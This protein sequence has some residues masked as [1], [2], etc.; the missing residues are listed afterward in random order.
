[1]TRPKYGLR[2]ALAI[3]LS[4]VLFHWPCNRLVS[5]ASAPYQAAAKPRHRTGSKTAARGQQIKEHRREIIKS[6]DTVQKVESPSPK[7]N[8]LLTPGVDDP[9]MPYNNLLATLPV[10]DTSEFE[11]P[12]RTDLPAIQICKFPLSPEQAAVM[13]NADGSMNI[14]KQ[15]PFTGVF[16][17]FDTHVNETGPLPTVYTNFK[18]I[19]T[20]F[21]EE[22]NLRGHYERWLFFDFFQLADPTAPKTAPRLAV[23]QVFQT[24]AWDPNTWERY[25]G[26][27]STPLPVGLP[28]CSKFDPDVNEA[29]AKHL[30]DMTRGL[31]WH[32]IELALQNPRWYEEVTDSVEGAILG[33]QLCALALK[34]AKRDEYQLWLHVGLARHES[35]SRQVRAGTARYFSILKRM[36]QGEIFLA[37]SG[38]HMF[39]GTDNPHG[40]THPGM[41]WDTAMEALSVGLQDMDIEFCQW[42]VSIINTPVFESYKV[43][44]N[45]LPGKLRHLAPLVDLYSK[46]YEAAIRGL[47]PLYDDDES[48]AD[49]PEFLVGFL[50][51]WLQARLHESGEDEVLSDPAVVS[52]LAAVRHDYD[53]LLSHAVNDYRGFV[54]PKPA[55]LITG[56]GQKYK[57]RRSKWTPHR[58]NRMPS[59]G[60]WLDYMR[61]R[62]PFIIS[63]EAINSTD[64]VAPASVEELYG[65]VGSSTDWGAAIGNP[66]TDKQQFNDPVQ[67]QRARAQEIQRRGGSSSSYI[68]L[69]HTAEESK[70][71]P[72]THPSANSLSPA[73]NSSCPLLMQAFGWRTC[74]WDDVYLCHKAGAETVSLARSNLDNGVPVFSGTSRLKR[75]Y[76]KYCDYVHMIFDPDFNITSPTYFDAGSIAERKSGASSIY[77]VESSTG[78][79][80]YG[81]PLDR[82]KEDIPIPEIFDKA[83]L[84]PKGVSFWMGAARKEMPGISG[85]HYDRF[86]N[87]HVLLRG[88]KEWKVFSPQDAMFMEYVV[89]PHYV[90]ASG[91][92]DQLQGHKQVHYYRYYGYNTVTRFSRAVTAHADMD[93]NY[94]ELPNFHKT[95]MGSFT[96]HAGEAVY[97]PSGWA[98]DVSSSG[99]H[100]AITYWFDCGDICDK[101]RTML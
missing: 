88:K 55:P 40:V 41:L 69:L 84:D 8:G 76:V 86:D 82:M 4:I 14:D 92:I 36:V 85:L 42:L 18:S 21:S 32:F 29:L 94:D 59:P 52:A 68:R 1:M 56:P 22:D 98:H 72:P 99:I 89:P 31:C 43:N 38:E 73:S 23:T 30:H 101:V 33:E 100:Q 10:R 75:E 44:G 61:R 93:Y 2:L 16:F 20:H 39:D 96:L 17:S 35:R 34:N 63:L 27:E 90:S 80:I 79:S 3:Y 5:A 95:T 7:Q 47:A 58:F 74:D 67:R 83:G 71:L 51:Q 64:E 19:L 28:N 78:R 97:L 66:V 48:G 53:E 65:P 45:L 9:K 49:G 54:L 26:P 70:Q 87:F 6:R 57:P 60:E 13:V 25:S 37:A 50:V 62:E 24:K 15:D 91:D 81:F 46:E 77:N 12:A 11:F